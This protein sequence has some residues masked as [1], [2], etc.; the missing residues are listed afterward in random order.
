[1]DELKL[2]SA[3]QGIW[4]CE[5]QHKCKWQGFALHHGLSWGTIPHDSNTWRQWHSREC[6]G[7]LIQLVEPKEGTLIKGEYK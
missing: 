7:A 2:A 1:M 5:Q 6:G 4:C 3:P